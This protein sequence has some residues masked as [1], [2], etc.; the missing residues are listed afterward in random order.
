MSIQEVL[1]VFD[2]VDTVSADVEAAKSDG[3]INIFDIPK[4]T[5]I[6]PVLQTTIS[7]ADQ[8]GEEAKNMTIDEFKVVF[9][10]SLTSVEGLA[11]AVA[12]YELPAEVV[13]VLEKAMDLVTLVLKTW[14]LKK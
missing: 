2:L 4:F 14:I 12:G 10:R 3:K 6:F 13:Q 11:K 9:E 1:N 7:G 5:D 8:I